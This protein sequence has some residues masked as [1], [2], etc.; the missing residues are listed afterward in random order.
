[1]AFSLDQSQKLAKVSFRARIPGIYTEVR[2]VMSGASIPR[3]VELVTTLLIPK[4]RKNAEQLKKG[5]VNSGRSGARL[6]IEWPG[7]PCVG[8]R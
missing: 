3:A 4:E 5:V 8:Q 2:S 1:M 6:P 7:A